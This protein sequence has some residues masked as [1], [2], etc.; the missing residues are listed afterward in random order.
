MDGELLDHLRAKLDQCNIETFFRGWGWHR[1]IIVLLFTIKIKGIQMNKGK[2][3][4]TVGNLIHIRDKGN[5][6]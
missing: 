2:V 3:H 4:K 6:V 1:I 5:N